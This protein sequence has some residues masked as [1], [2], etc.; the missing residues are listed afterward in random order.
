MCVCGRGM[1]GGEIETNP[2]ARVNMCRLW[3]HSRS[4][5]QACAPRHAETQGEG[6]QTDRQAGRQTDRPHDR[7]PWLSERQFG[8]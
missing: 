5:A 3:M 6:A 7:I 4:S 1:G 2:M 8:E